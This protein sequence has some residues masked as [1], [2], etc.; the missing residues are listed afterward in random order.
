MFRIT[1][2]SYLN[3]FPFVFGLKKSGFLQN[4]TLDLQVPSICARKLI[5][6]EADIALIPTGAIPEAGKLHY[7]SDYCIGATGPVQTVLL[8]SR[9]PLDEISTIHLDFDSRTSVELIRVLAKHHWKITPDWVN[10]KSG[11]DSSSLLPESVVAIGD[12]TFALR[13]H[14]PFVYDLA[15]NWV[16]FADAPFVFAVW[17]TKNELSPHDISAFN[18]ALTFG[19]MHKAESLDY[20]RNNLPDCGNCL[21]YLENSISY[22]FDSEKKRGLKL[23]LDFLKENRK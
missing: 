3:T 21:D 18:Q 8:L 6:G 12:K 2:V 10:L 20:F 17:A 9:V 22:S 16:I 4:F 15:E 14:Y 23:F 11:S 7:L 1:A 19:I 5:E 13:Q